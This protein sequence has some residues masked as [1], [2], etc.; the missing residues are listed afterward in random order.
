[1]EKLNENRK[2]C[3]R[4]G[5]KYEIIKSK[6]NKSKYCSW[7]CKKHKIQKICKTCGKKYEIS[8]CFKDSNHFCSRKCIR[9]SEEA[10]NKI[11]EKVK[12][13]FKNGMPQQTKNKISLTLKG[14]PPGNK[15]K[16]YKSPKQSK[17]MKERGHWKKG[18]TF[19]DRFGIEKAQE[20]KRK[21]S[22]YRKSLVKP[23]DPKYRDYKCEVNRIT[24][25]QPIYL[26]ENYDK[27]GKARKG[28]DN[29]QLDHIIP[30]RYGY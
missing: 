3:I 6:E 5:K 24:Y 19:E 1:M 21:Q 15:G 28:T 7:E 26:L 17:T 13:Q 27:R 23:K 16:K 12:E 8:N 14:R 4:C 18:Q 11:R 22:E 20:I 10:K 9:K 2:I 25:K 30:I 29:Y